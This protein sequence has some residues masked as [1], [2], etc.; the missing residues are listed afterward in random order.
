[1]TTKDLTR[2]DLRWMDEP[3]KSTQWKNLY[4][5]KDGKSVDAL[6]IHPTEDDAKEMAKNTMDKGFVFV[7][8]IKAN[9]RLRV[10]DI[11]HAIQIPIKS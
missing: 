4:F 6:R 7:N 10:S 11:S 3:I 9:I 1:M 2:K 5:M 8:L